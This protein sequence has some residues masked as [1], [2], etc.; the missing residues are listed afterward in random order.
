MVFSIGYCAIDSRYIDSVLSEFKYISGIRSITSRSEYWK[1]LWDH[2]RSPFTASPVSNP[3]SSIPF[4]GNAETYNKIISNL[5]NRLDIVQ[6]QINVL[7]GKTEN[8]VKDSIELSEDFNKVKYNE[9]FTKFKDDLEQISQE[10]NNL[11]N[12]YKNQ[13]DTIFDKKITSN[14][15]KLVQFEKEIGNMKNVLDNYKIEVNELL[16]TKSSDFDLQKLKKE[17]EGMN[18]KIKD[19]NNKASFSSSK[20]SEKI[21]ENEKKLTV[22]HSEF[23]SL[24]D[25]FKDIQN[26]LEK[27]GGSNT[28]QFESIHNLFNNANQRLIEVEDK[29]NKLNI[30]RLLSFGEEDQQQN[31]V[32]YIDLHNRQ[33]E[34]HEQLEE[35]KNKWGELKSGLE[36]NEKRLSQFSETLKSL[37]QNQE[38][39][40]KEYDKL[41]EAIPEQVADITEKTLRQ[42]IV[43]LPDY[44]LESGGA[45]V[46]SK[47]TS[48]TYKLQ[49]EGFIGTLSNILGVAIK[50]GRPPTEAIKPTVHAGECWAMRGSEGVL[51]LKLAKSIIPSQITVEHL[52]KEIS[53]SIS[54]APRYIEVYAIQDIKAFSAEYITGNRG[55]VGQEKPHA[56]F[57][58]KVEYDPAKKSLQTFELFHHLDKPIQY[59]QFQFLENWGHP[60]YTCIYRIRV[61]GTPVTLPPPIPENDEE[62]ISDSFRL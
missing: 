39:L 4:V 15:E 25:K 21:N 22:L 51:T 7:T 46:I 12:N 50:P 11:Q 2:V 27:E 59:I 38:E 10:I 41:V 60:D 18:E 9:M 52:A 17:I 31:I 1:S 32:N 37:S 55:L 26:Q 49:P 62:E 35:M 36:N 29:M 61:H 19:L 33:K 44:A 56:L 45:R 43:G 23:S 5:N 57:I 40:S 48:E 14:N 13:I 20:D 8:L 30:D 34:D 16:N 3:P 6:A 53:F 54:S 24:F 28:Q 58:G 42:D 47:L